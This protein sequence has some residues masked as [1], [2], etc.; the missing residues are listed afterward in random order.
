MF[1]AVFILYKIEHCSEGEYCSDP[2][3][4]DKFGDKCTFLIILDEAIGLDLMVF[5]M[6][7][8]NNLIIN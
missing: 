7:E 6:G 8:I 5:V 3:N 2:D 1:N 4:S